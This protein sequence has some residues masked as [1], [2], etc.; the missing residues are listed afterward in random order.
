M[1]SSFSHLKNT[2]RL[3]ICLHWT[4]IKYLPF[5]IKFFV[6]QRQETMSLKKYG[7][8]QGKQQLSLF[9][10]SRQCFI[11]VLWDIDFLN[12]LWSSYSNF[13]S[14]RIL[15][16][17]LWGISWGSIEVFSQLSSLWKKNNSYRINWESF[18]HGTHGYISSSENIVIN[19][20][21]QWFMFNFQE[22]ASPFHLHKKNIQHQKWRTDILSC[23]QFVLHAG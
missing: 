17:W 3:F 21:C 11:S 7:K 6:T 2:W 1:Q 4:L 8:L 5:W 20:F 18:I 12:Q 23:M 14:S 9:Q 13:P 15:C 22:Y 16:T 10:S 19:S